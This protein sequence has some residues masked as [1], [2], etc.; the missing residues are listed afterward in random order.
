MQREIIHECECEICQNQGSTEIR[1][2]HHLMNVF[3]NR[4]DEQERR[5]YAALEA[6]KLGQGGLEKVAQ[7][8]GLHVNTIRR[9]K[10]EM[11]QDLSGRPQD[12]V[13]VEGGGRKRLEKKVLKSQAN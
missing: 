10:A 3:I 8:T 4:L 1:Q 7:I 11:L 6:K 9:G 12:R 13:R 5:W 2:M